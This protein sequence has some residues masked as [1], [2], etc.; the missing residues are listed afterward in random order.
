MK[1]SAQ[2]PA[3]VQ[4]PWKMDFFLLAAIWGSS[5]LFMRMGTVE[6][7]A[8]PTAGM[9]VMIA[10]AFLVPLVLMRGFGTILLQNWKLTMLAGILNSG[11]PF[12]CFGFALLSISTGLSAILNA[13]V[14]LFGAVIAWVWLGNKLHGSRVVGLILGFAGVV[15]LAWDKA[16]FRPDASG[17][18]SGWAVLACL[19][20]TFCYGVAAS[21]TKRFLQGVPS[22]V[23]ATGSQIGA[24]V[25][26]LPLT[27]AYWPE[28]GVSNTAWLAVLVLGVLCSGIS[29]VIYFR[30]IERA[31]PTRALSVTFGIPVFALLYGTVV[32]GEAITAWM[33]V[34]GVI[35]V[36][37]ISLSTGLVQ[38]WLKAT[39]PTPQ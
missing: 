16:S 1:D 14:P 36:L 10:T 28:H 18:S 2:A 38:S 15:L 24:S 19:L 34:C 30:M 4:I 22:L 39:Q 31:G 9:R 3:P 27:I 21:F 25:G 5:F 32:L 11:I 12:A 23:A 37:G 8:F 13:T 17:Y 29:Y 7:G 33:L 6:F 35:I 26:L 20:A